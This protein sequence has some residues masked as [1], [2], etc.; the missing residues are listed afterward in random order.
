MAM[1]TTNP[2]VVRMQ[3][4][5]GS[6]CRLYGSMRMYRDERVVGR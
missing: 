5:G 6:R 3:I 1:N 4:D 2:K